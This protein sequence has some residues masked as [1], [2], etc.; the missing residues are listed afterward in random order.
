MGFFLLLQQ[1]MRLLEAAHLF[2]Q[3]DFSRK[4]SRG[5]PSCSTADLFWQLWKSAWSGGTKI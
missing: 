4:P 3:Q 2:P 5:L 1:K